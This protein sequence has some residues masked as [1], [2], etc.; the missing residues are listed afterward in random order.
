MNAFVFVLQTDDRGWLSPCGRPAICPPCD[1][2]LPLFQCN[3]Q[4]V[5]IIRTTSPLFQESDD[6][7]AHNH[8]P[9]ST[10]RGRSAGFKGR[11]LGTF[12]PYRPRGRRDPPSTAMSSLVFGALD[13]P[14]SLVTGGRWAGKGGCIEAVVG[15]IFFAPINSRL[16]GQKD[17]RNERCH[18]LRWFGPAR[19][20]R[21]DVRLDDRGGAKDYNEIFGSW[22]NPRAVLH[23]RCP[24]RR[25]TLHDESAF[26]D[27][28]PELT[29]SRRLR[30]ETDN[31]PP[32]NHRVESARQSA[33]VRRGR[34]VVKVL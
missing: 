18:R 7:N 11:R 27:P 30:Y 26:V 31:S 21:S 17:R 1:A 14:G 32:P 4:I 6:Q 19:R 29:R 12:G 5:F 22:F 20:L 3:R 13:S 33:S 15:E 24:T 9:E 10:S 16:C 34:E 2:R 23:R 25:P 8:R 28:S